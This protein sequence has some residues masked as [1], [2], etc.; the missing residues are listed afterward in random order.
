MTLLCVQK[1]FFVLFT[2]CCQRGKHVGLSEC[3]RVDAGGGSASGVCLEELE[4]VF[5]DDELVGV[6]GYL[7]H[8]AAIGTLEIAL[9]VLGRPDALEA[10]A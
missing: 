3:G 8:A 2:C 4:H 7:V 5:V 6:G 10:G 1:Q 9:V